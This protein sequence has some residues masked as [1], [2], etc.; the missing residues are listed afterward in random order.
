MSGQPGE[1]RPATT[2]SPA[3]RLLWRSGRAV[4]LE[5]GSRRVAID[6]VAAPVVGELVG[7]RRSHSAAQLPTTLRVQEQLV[8]TRFLWPA[9]RAATDPDDVRLA[10]PRP[11]LA[12]ELAALTARHGEQAA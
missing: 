8:A 10:P 7:R 2:L 3:A 11:R 4:Q 5:L 12:P 9:D 6:G 1:E